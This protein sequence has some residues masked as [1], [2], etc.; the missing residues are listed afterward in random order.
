MRWL[1][2]PMLTVAISACGAPNVSV[3]ASPSGTPFPSRLIVGQE[4]TIGHA[5]MHCGLQVMELDGDPWLIEKSS[6]VGSPGLDPEPYIS[7]T[8]KLLSHDD[9]I[10]RGNVSF[11]MHRITP[12][13]SIGPCF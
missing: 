2:A 8:V 6:I 7:G 13:P 11:S 5:T 12:S 1:I 4:Y 3:T 10:F 9:A